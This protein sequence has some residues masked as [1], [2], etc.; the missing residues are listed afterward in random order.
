MA[1]NPEREQTK[2]GDLNSNDTTRVGMRKPYVAPTLE[3][4]GDIQAITKNVGMTGNSDGAPG[5]GKG[6]TQP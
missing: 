4:Y 1:Q 6:F 5:M 3:R 2:N